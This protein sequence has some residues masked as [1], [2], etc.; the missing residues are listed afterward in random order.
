M[1]VSGGGWVDRLRGGGWGTRYGGS[2]S[3]K[4]LQ[5]LDRQRLASLQKPH[6]IGSVVIPRERFE[7][8][9][10]WLALKNIIRGL[11]LSE[12]DRHLCM[13]DEP[14]W[15]DTCQNFVT[16]RAMSCLSSPVSA[17][18]AWNAWVHDPPFGEENGCIL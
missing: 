18:Y 17:V 1:G 15:R 16:K 5:I 11:T 10:T 6:A 7:H 3:K 4:N 14:L 2:G 9:L 13:R 8:E 12:K